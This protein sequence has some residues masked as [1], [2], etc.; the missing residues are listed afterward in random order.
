MTTIIFKADGTTEVIPGPAFDPDEI[1]NEDARILR[2][3]LARFMLDSGQTPA[4][5][6]ARFAAAKRA[7]D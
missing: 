3:V 2:R 4:Q 6:Q 5:V 1:P 7:V